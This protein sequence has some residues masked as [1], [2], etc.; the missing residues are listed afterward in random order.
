MVSNVCSRSHG[1]PPVARRRAMISTSRSNLSPVLF[2]ES[3]DIAEREKTGEKAR[4]IRLAPAPD[5]NAGEG[6]FRMP[7]RRFRT[8]VWC[9]LPALR[10]GLW[11]MNVPEPAYSAF[12]RF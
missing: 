11:M 2:W 5:R 1:Q 12:Q 10:F 8:T 9:R 7:R 6:Y 4:I 3:D